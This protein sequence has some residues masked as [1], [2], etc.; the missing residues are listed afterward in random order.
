MSILPT[1]EPSSPSSPA[2]TTAQKWSVQTPPPPPALF[3]PRRSLPDI[4]PSKEPRRSLPDAETGLSSDVL[5]LMLLFCE[6][7]SSGD[8]SRFT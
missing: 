7:G 2:A 4:D 8:G 3:E 6:L 5:R 1:R